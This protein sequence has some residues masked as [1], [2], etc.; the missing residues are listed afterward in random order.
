M[1][2][3]RRQRRLYV[4]VYALALIALYPYLYDQLGFIAVLLF[5]LASP[6]YWSGRIIVDALTEKP[7][8]ER[9]QQVAF[10]GFKTAYEILVVTIL[11][12]LAVNSY[13]VP[14]R[15]RVLNTYFLLNSEVLLNFG[16]LLLLAVVLPACVVAWYEPDPIPADQQT[17]SGAL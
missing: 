12:S 3:S 11:V 4:V 7:L 10:Q 17:E 9:E 1:S 2:L 8:D 16:S 5:A 13:P 6:L 15:H 14:D